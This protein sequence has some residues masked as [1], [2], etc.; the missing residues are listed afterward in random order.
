MN[1]KVGLEA[2]TTETLSLPVRLANNNLF[3]NIVCKELTPEIENLYRG[4]EDTYAL[5][6]GLG[7]SV[8]RF[9]FKEGQV[10]LAYLK[11]GIDETTGYPL[12]PDDISLITA[13]TYYCKWKISER[14]RW[15][16]REGFIREAQ[17]AEAHWLKYVKQTRNKV[18]RP[19]TRDD[20][21]NLKDSSLYMIPDHNK[22]NNFFGNLNR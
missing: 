22:Y 11:V 18:R 13:I 17:D 8:L 19:K 20:F 12:V 14:K 9:S 5:I 1:I 6:G 4:C 2:L 21:Q 3:H 10:A 16:G 15:E 7:K